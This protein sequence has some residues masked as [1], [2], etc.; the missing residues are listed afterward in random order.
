MLLFSR[1]LHS[2]LYC[3]RAVPSESHFNARQVAHR[4]RRGRCTA[5][6]TQLLGWRWSS[7]HNVRLSEA[8]AKTI[9][10]GSLI[11]IGYLRTK[12]RIM[13][14]DMYTYMT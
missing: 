7:Q 6:A 13:S 9:H 5:D 14:F 4:F 8:T 10:S 11:A 12:V 1:I 2:E 3:L